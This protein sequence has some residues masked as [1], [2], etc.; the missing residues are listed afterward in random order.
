MGRA[1]SPRDFGGAADLGLRSRL[2][3][4]APLALASVL[5]RAAL[6]SVLGRT[7]E[8]AW[9]TGRGTAKRWFAQRKNFKRSHPQT[10]PDFLPRQSQTGGRAAVC[11]CI[12]YIVPVKLF[13]LFP[14][15]LGLGESEERL[16]ARCT[17]HPSKAWMG[18]PSLWGWSCQF[19]RLVGGSVAFAQGQNDNVECRGEIQGPSLRSE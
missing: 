14:L 19:N 4:G 13:P 18:H 8:R 7:N 9:R 2:V 6:I 15:R 16:R 11:F 3:Y 5:E 12:Y 1:F 10:E 17:S